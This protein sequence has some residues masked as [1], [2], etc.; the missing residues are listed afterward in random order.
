MQDEEHAASLGWFMC[1]HSLCKKCV[2]LY[3]EQ[4][5]VC[6]C[7]QFRGQDMALLAQ[8]SNHVVLMPN[9]KLPESLL[10]QMVA[11]GLYYELSRSV[12]S[13]VMRS[14]RWSRYF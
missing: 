2:C 11:M 5:P 8:Y 7:R 1:N 6:R 9:E 12:R 10:E 3:V 4:C 13:G 14:C